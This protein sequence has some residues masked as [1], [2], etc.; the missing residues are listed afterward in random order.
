MSQDSNNFTEMD[1]IS[2]DEKVQENLKMI[3]QMNV[4]DLLA[5]TEACLIS[6]RQLG[7]MIRKMVAKPTI[8]E[9]VSQR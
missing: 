4:S 6:Y 1:T 9:E 8:D 2:H 3:R 7:E 5:L